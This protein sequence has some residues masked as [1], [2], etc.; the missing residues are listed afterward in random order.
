MRRCCATSGC[1][2]CATSSGWA[3]GRGAMRPIR[4]SG[5]ANASGCTTERYRGGVGRL[6]RR[7]PLDVIDD[8]DVNGGFHGFELQAELL[9]DGGKEAGRR[10]GIGGIGLVIGVA[11]LEVIAAGE[12]SLIDDRAV[13]DE[14]LQ[15]HGEIRHG[16]AGKSQVGFGPMPAAVL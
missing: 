7:G 10:V 11:Q 13:V 9:L 2:R 12:A 16:E 14:E 1:C 15:A 4:W 5:A 6:I 8:E 3:S